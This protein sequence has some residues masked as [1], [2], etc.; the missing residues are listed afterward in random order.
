MKINKLLIFFFLT[1]LFLV[2]A[3]TSITKSFS[4]PGKSLPQ[5][6]I[7]GKW[8]MLIQTDGDLT[9]NKI[10][11]QLNFRI[12]GIV[13]YKGDGILYD[14]KK[15]AIFTITETKKW[16]INNSYL[17]EKQVK[18]SLTKIAGDQ[19]LKIQVRNI[20]ES[21]KKDRENR[22]WKWEIVA[23]TTEALTLQAW[24]SKGET[25]FFTYYKIE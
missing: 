21:F 8:A 20:Y 14:G 11:L 9:S 15:A 16:H 10:Y 4:Q 2:Q 6:D 7:V 17:Y 24:D 25:E 12:D 13:E 23:I 22:E 3:C 5:N 18:C 1:N 19:D